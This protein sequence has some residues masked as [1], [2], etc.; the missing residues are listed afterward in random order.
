METSFSL[1][2]PLASGVAGTQIVPELDVLFVLLPAEKD[3]FAA[4]DGGKINQA[5]V[6]VFDLNL[7]LLKFAQDLFDIGQCFGPLVD[8]FASGIVAGGEEGGQPLV[9]LVEL[10]AQL[11]KVLQPLPDRRQ[12]PARFVA[13]IM[14]LEEIT[15]GHFAGPVPAGKASSFMLTRS[16]GS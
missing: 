1:S 3:L 12:Q 9:V 10:L 5:A 4:E 14:L 13:G 16:F 7:P 8:R 2:Q 6:E 15:H 11:G